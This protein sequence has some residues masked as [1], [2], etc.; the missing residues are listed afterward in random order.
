M[1]GLK[2]K[3]ELA[4][5][6]HSMAKSYQMVRWHNVTYLPVDFE[7]RDSSVPPA[8][9]RTMWLP[10]N[11]EFIGRLAA[12]QYSTLFAS[13]G[14]L[15]SFDFMLSQN[16]IYENSESRTLQVRTPEGL[17]VLNE[18]G[19]L[20]PAE[21]VF[22]PNTISPLL[23]G[24]RA[25]KDE[26]F[27]VIA[28]WLD[29]EEEAHSL[30]NHLATALA[31]GYSAVKLVI[32]LGEGRNGKG[33]LLKMIHKLL[34]TENVSNVT[35]QQIAE[36]SPVVT[37]LNGKLINIIYD[38]QA[39]YVKDSGLEKTLIAGEPASIRPLY[40]STPVVVR[41]NALFIESLNKEPKSN[42]KTP[43][44]QKRLV[45]FQFPNVYALDHRFERLMLSDER[46]G[47][48][49]SLLIDHYVKEDDVAE[50]LALT[51]KAMELQLEHMYVNSVALQFL[52]HL[53]ETDTL[54][55]TGLLGKPI[56]EWVASF[57]SWRV[58]ENDLGNWAEPD[59]VA[60]FTPLVN[61]ERRSVRTATGPRKSRVV[62]S[63]KAEGTAFI[64]SL[65]GDDD[66]DTAS[67]EA[68]VED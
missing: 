19:S 49:L 24:D 41:T 22:V 61:T 6:A 36:S 62:T 47:A 1:L 31:P 65:E 55:A 38:A 8:P 54:G 16:A 57:Q 50:K 60:L 5:D 63:F 25:A 39:T 37:Q 26:V 28:Q 32:L 15:R 66:G 35:R 20:T 4:K 13:D 23:N 53:H 48:F 9:E 14:E 45:R 58:K 42:D 7:T 67:E 2:T 33:L 18:D 30:L 52:K 27:E 59:V 56:A 3:G 10:I 46:I 11:R 68:V 43:A 51:A 17:M 29:S 40:E 44:L 21:G 64:E 34:G 12:D